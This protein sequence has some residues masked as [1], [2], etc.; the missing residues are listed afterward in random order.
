MDEEPDGYAEEER[1]RHDR[2]EA[3]AKKRSDRREAKHEGWDADED[4]AQRRADDAKYGERSAPNGRAVQ[5]AV[6]EDREHDERRRRQHVKVTAMVQRLRD[7]MNDVRQAGE[8]DVRRE[9]RE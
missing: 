3:T 4:R 2:D 8:D 5:Q 6:E 9:E 1:L 7:R